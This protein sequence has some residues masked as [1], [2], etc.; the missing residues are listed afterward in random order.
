MP[1]VKSPTCEPRRTKRTANA[2][3]NGPMLAI[4]HAMGF[5]PFIADV[6]WQ[7]PVEKVL[8]HLKS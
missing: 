7:I 3:S 6:A 2:D 8:E 4:N 5:K 1:T